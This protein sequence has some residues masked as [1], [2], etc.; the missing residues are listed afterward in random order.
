MKSQKRANFEP[1]R[2]K[3]R[4]I[5]RE[6]EW[7]ERQKQREWWKSER[8]TDYEVVDSQKRFTN[9]KKIRYLT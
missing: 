9:I 6:R 8:K 7:E 4:E 1:G 5:E 2:Q 3:E